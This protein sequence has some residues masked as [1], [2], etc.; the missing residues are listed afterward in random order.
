M[1]SGERENGGWEGERD[2]RERARA[3]ERERD[4]VGQADVDT[5]SDENRSQG[6]VCMVST[7]RGWRLNY[8]RVEGDNLNLIPIQKKLADFLH[9]IT[10]FNL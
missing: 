7:V 3:E 6:Y 2:C 1:Q 9:V 10:S 5:T 8:G 4:A